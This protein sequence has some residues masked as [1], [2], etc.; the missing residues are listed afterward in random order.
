MSGKNPGPVCVLYCHG[1]S[2]CR[3]EAVPIARK[4]C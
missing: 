1:N 3:M 4:I 2:G